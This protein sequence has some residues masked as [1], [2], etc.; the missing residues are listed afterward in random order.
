MTF[1]LCLVLEPNA[2]HPNVVKRLHLAK[3]YLDFFF[4]KFIL[5]EGWG[6]K[7]FLVQFAF[8]KYDESE[9]LKSR[10]F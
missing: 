4:Y 6:Q 10:T 1:Q 9:T 3:L 7:F 5:V 8:V 2:V